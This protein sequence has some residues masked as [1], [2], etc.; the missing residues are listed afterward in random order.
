MGG[1]NFDDDDIGNSS[2]GASSDDEPGGFSAPPAPVPSTKPTKAGPVSSEPPEPNESSAP[3]VTTPAPITPPKTTAKAP[4]EP[5][6]VI[7]PAAPV[8]KPVKTGPIIAS[9]PEDP[10]RTSTPAPAKRPEVGISVPPESP[11]DSG[12]IGGAADYVAPAPGATE[13]VKDTPVGV[14]VAAKPKAEPSQPSQPVAPPAA[15]KIV[16]YNAPKDTN[17]D[18][19]ILGDEP[20]V[21]TDYVPP[22]SAPQAKPEV[23][24]AKPI[25]PA[26]VSSMPRPAPETLVGPQTIGLN[27]ATGVDNP[28]TR[29]LSI[30]T[31]GNIP[32]AP[33]DQTPFKVGPDGLPTDEP[34]PNT[35]SPNTGTTPNT[36]VG[37]KRR[38]QKDEDAGYV[39]LMTNIIIVEDQEDIREKFEGTSFEQ[40]LVE[41]PARFFLVE[42]A[43]GKRLSAQFNPTEVED[44]VEVGYS[45]LDPPG[46]SFSHM[47]YSSTKN[48]TVEM[49]L[50]WTALSTA[51]LVL[52]EDAR[53]TLWSWCYP[54]RQVDAYNGGISQGPPVLIATWPNLFSIE[55]R[56]LGMK[57]KYLRFNSEGYATRWVATVKIE[58]CRDAY[59]SPF[60]SSQDI[61]KSTR[62]LGRGSPGERH[63]NLTTLKR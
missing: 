29:N 8:T 7:T 26:E 46:A 28:A 22:A 2:D 19:S 21:V 43:T 50:Y 40:A 6:Q 31:V 48:Y 61:Q 47:H 10:T 60:L 58:E 11:Q 20:V 51:Q 12:F 52:A 36:S 45:R 5:K 41:A 62:Y 24:P 37:P 16:K 30:E 27:D 44:E 18:D 57:M 56:L 53:R 15:P 55:C 35:P 17:D 25:N 49:E 63:T 4:V 32:E 9:T 59:L 54:N 33:T 14:P 42:A 34:P 38:G 3:P 23:G 39:S 13:P 1:S